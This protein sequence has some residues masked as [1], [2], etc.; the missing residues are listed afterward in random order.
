MKNLYLIALTLLL[1]VACA[2][3]SGGTSRIEEATAKM[4]ELC[5]QNVSGVGTV[6]EFVVD[7]NML[8]IVCVVTNT[9]LKYSE[10]E[11]DKD[12]I[13]EQLKITISSVSRGKLLDVLREGDTGICYRYLWPDGKKL[14]FSFPFSEV[15]QLTKK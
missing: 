11:A 10:M 8:T 13:R 2:A 12:N 4:N 5:P 1:S 7:N 3:C 9:A 14:D 15:E 6:K